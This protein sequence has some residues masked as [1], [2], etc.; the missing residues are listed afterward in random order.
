MWPQS[1]LMDALSDSKHFFNTD[2]A[3]TWSA[4]VAWIREMSTGRDAM[5][6]DNLMHSFSSQSYKL[7][8]ALKDSGFRKYT[9]RT[10]ESRMRIKGKLET[11]WLTPQGCDL[12]NANRLRRAK[13][14]DDLQHQK[15]IFDFEEN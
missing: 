5:E 14:K 2:S 3:T 7:I 15:T 10:G 4:I 9:S 8:N 13:I 11:I 6:V 1:I 12:H